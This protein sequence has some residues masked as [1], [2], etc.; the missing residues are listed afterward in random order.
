MR[1]NKRLTSE[2]RGDEIR[3]NYLIGALLKRE[4][5][6]AKEIITSSFEIMERKQHLGCKSINGREQRLFTIDLASRH[7]S[8]R[9]LTRSRREAFFLKFVEI[10]DRQQ[11]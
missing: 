7:D 9:K 5:L 4:K 11:N 3:V 8:D 6:R 2:V 10:L 1:K